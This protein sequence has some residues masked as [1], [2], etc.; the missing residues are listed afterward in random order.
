M[1]MKTIG[2]GVLLTA[3]V[4]MPEFAHGHQATELYIPIGSSPGI[5]ASRAYIGKISRVDYASSSMDVSG[6]KGAK[7]IRVNE[8]TKYYLDRSQ[9]GKKNE[10]GDMHDCEV[11]RRIEVNVAD[12][13]TVV[14]IKIESL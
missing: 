12:D 6:E 8:Q 9:H 14:W 11:G 7:S 3:L 1:N 10:I 5:S 13:G 2:I 4:S